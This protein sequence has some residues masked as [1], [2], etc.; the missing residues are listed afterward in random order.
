MWFAA[1]VDQVLKLVT[2]IIH[3]F[4]F[5][6]F[7]FETFHEEFDVAQFNQLNLNSFFSIG[8]IYSQKWKPLERVWLL[9]NMGIIEDPARHHEEVRSIFASKA[10]C[11]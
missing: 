9:Y 10:F 6:V 11:L 1:F 2:V 5:N 8:L 7:V 3:L 4:V